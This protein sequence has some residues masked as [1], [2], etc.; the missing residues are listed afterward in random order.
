MIP[1]LL[2]TMLLTSSFSATG[3]AAAE[4]SADRPLPGGTVVSID[5]ESASLTLQLPSGE[6]RLLVVADQRLLRDIR[7]H[8]H[9]IFEMNGAG[10]VTKFLKLPTDPAN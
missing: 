6:L 9:V 2:L 7:I 8:D 1:L 10:E 5:Q 4:K 3:S